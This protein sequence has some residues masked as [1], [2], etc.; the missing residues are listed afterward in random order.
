MSPSFEAPM[1]SC[2]SGKSAAV[3]KDGFYGPSEREVS[4]AEQLR[5]SYPLTYI[6]RFKQACLV[7]TFSNI[8]NIH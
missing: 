1:L 2:R 4:E 3:C 5:K 7:L 6:K 8:K